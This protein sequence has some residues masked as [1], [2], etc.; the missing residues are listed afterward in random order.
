MH[1]LK[2]CSLIQLFVIFICIFSNL[3]ISIF[4]FAQ[5]PNYKWVVSASGNRDDVPYSICT[6]ANGNTFVAGYFTSTKTNFGGIVLTNSSTTGSNEAFLAKYNAYGNLLWAKSVGG[7]TYEISY[8]ICSDVNGNVFMSGT[9]SASYI[10]IGSTKLTNN[11]PGKD[12]MFLAK[13]DASGNVLWAK[14]AG[15]SSIDRGCSISTDASG[16]VI[17]AGFFVSPT[18]TFGSTTLTST[19]S[20][21]IFLAK[22]DA[23]GNVL[24]AKSAGGTDTDE[25]NSVCTD[26]NGNIIV[27]GNF[28]SSSITFDSTTLTNMN[29]SWGDED[30]FL[31]KYDSSGNVIWAKSAGGTYKDYTNS[32]CTDANGNILC[33]GYF[34]SLTISFDSITLANVKNTGYADIF[35]SKYDASGNVLWA[36]SL[37][38]TDD[39]FANSI[40]SDAKGNITI[41]GDFL[42]SSI[43]FGSTTLYNTAYSLSFDEAQLFI[44]QYDSS[45]NPLWAESAGED[46]D[47]IAYAVASHTDGSFVV[48]G[49]F[50]DETITFG[51]AT[52]TNTDPI[53]Y[54]VGGCD[55]FITK[56]F[57]PFSVTISQTSVSCNGGSDG[58]ATATAAGS[59]NPPY[60][61]LWNTNPAQ[62]TQTA[63]GLMGGNYTVTVTD[64]KGN[65]T[66]A[67]V[68]IS[69][70][71]A[72]T[73]TITA[74]GSTTLCQGDSITLTAS[75]A[76]S[77]LWSNNAISQSITVSSAGN[78]AVTVIDANGCTGTS[79]QKKVTVNTNP[80]PTIT[81]SGATTFCQG[82]SVT[83][84]ASSGASYL[85]SNGETSKSIVVST[86]GNYS[87][88][89]TNSK[90]CTGSS[91][92]TTVTVY[93][94]PLS[95]NLG[96][97]VVLCNGTSA[98][99]SVAS[100]FTTYLWS[101]GSNTN[102]ITVSS[103]GTYY[104]SVTDMNGCSASD[105][106][107]VSANATSGCNELF[108]SEY[109]EGSSNNKA[110]EIYNPTSA[111]V[112]LSDYKIV[113]YNNGGTTASSTIT[114]SGSI[115][116]KDVYVICHTSASSSLLSLA[117]QSSGSLNFNG[118]DVV[119]LSKNGSIID[120]IGEIGQS[121][122]WTVGT[123]ST[124]NYT[125]VRKSSV[126]ATQ[127]NW[128][129]GATEWDV[130]AMDTYSYLG[131]HTSSCTNGNSSSAGAGADVSICQGESTTLN[132]SGGSSYLWNTSGTLSSL[133]IASPT[134][135]PASTTTYV[136][137]IT[138]GNAC[139]TT[140]EVTVTV[141]SIPSIT[142]TLNG[143]VITANQ[144]GADYQWLDCNNSY[145]QITGA[146]NQS[147]SVTANGDYAVMVTQNNC[148]DTSA[149]I[150]VVTDSINA[151]FSAGSTTIY[152][153]NSVT[154]TD[155]TS[156]NPTLWQWTL[157]GGT[158]SSSTSQNPTITYNTAGT[159]AVTLYASDGTYNDTETK[160][161]YITVL[162]TTTTNGACDTITNVPAG[163]SALIY[164]TSK[165]G[166]ITGHNGYSDKAFADYFSSYSAGSQL[167]G[168]IMYFGVA[169]YSTSSKKI[170]VKAWDNTGS[171]GSPGSVLSTANVKI[172][173]I[174][175]DISNQTYT[176]VTFANPVTISAPFYLGFEVSYA[177][178][179]TVAIYQN[180]D[181]ETASSTAWT[182]FSTNTW[183]NFNSTSNWD[184]EVSL[185]ISAILCPTSPITSIN[186][187]SVLSNVLLFPNPSSGNVNL[188]IELTQNED[189]AIEIYNALG[190]KIKSDVLVN[191]NGGTFNL[192]LKNSSK[193]VYYVKVKTATD[194]WEQRL[195]L[196][197]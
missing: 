175:T 197:N 179:D 117:N 181:G 94:N 22:Y 154:F 127:T 163:S 59:S 104:I 177:A 35:L 54:E 185:Y 1:N 158:P 99:L 138:D 91:T 14:S 180:D 15:G 29:A 53:L 133:T 118:N 111:T 120:E 189:I 75:S 103:T 10:T 47:D 2:F 183:Y 115:A 7:S 6:D 44:A 108:I 106:V 145:S 39:D 100:G 49:T 150:N 45:G 128:T 125:L 20:I 83:L 37:G 140:D 78:Y 159:Y 109:V 156:G 62:S 191:S 160:S 89:V 86:S 81:A 9:F 30:I 87:V 113:E 76:T 193:G 69:Q 190:D 82:D 73:P 55:I 162:A 71:S 32:V 40:C 18:I 85:W 194:F 56:F 74:S 3:L 173:D 96:G 132:A 165:G 58:T 110:L 63:S 43:V 105:T 84:T 41:V 196:I 102:S 38:G 23:S 134:A 139:T 184:M 192:D 46:G 166:Y 27:A 167:S 17:V 11:T 136:V 135:T 142:T 157:S 31:T 195:V 42:S 153:G 24:W 137:T 93:S 188:K 131:S 187:H 66:T 95:V 116:A 65:T 61:Y 25:A 50:K 178:G 67:N 171:S 129:T 176:L 141:N 172:S 19:G 79:A 114:L 26:A 90:G 170:A 36:K 161:S 122:T 126:T 34:K 155:A 144:N 13:Y 123:G 52:L 130:Y 77:Y 70:P 146:S 164:S 98:T 152:E 80:S 148:R 124:E 97:D 12:D 51:S 151:D 168:A 16:N 112:T 8:S 169:E 64:S 121:T 33:A 48:T 5:E 72:V 149:C 119:A 92:T 28:E 186:E 57:A 88:A 4:S 60:T 68:S 21:D 147:Y 143:I 107:V 182:K 101:T 174:A